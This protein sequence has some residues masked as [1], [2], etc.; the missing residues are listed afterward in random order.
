[1]GTHAEEQKRTPKGG[2]PDVGKLAV[3]RVDQQFHDDLVILARAGMNTTDAVRWAVNHMANCVLA[4][5][6]RGTCPEGTVP[7][8]TTWVAPPKAKTQVVEAEEVA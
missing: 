7:K 2:P 1:M 4:A 8:M 6:V 5:W 3:A